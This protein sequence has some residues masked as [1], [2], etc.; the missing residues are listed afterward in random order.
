[1]SEVRY[2]V[3]KLFPVFGDGIEVSLISPTFVSTYLTN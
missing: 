2:D 1:M 3:N